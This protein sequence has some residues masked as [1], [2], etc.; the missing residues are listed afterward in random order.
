MD[1]SLSK[2]Q[3][4]VK[5]MEAWYTVVHGVSESQTWLGNRTTKIILYPIILFLIS[6]IKEL[7]EIGL[8]I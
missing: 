5:D 3:E 4:L 1:K 8:L 7:V 6:S 2:P